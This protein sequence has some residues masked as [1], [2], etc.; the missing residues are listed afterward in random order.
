MIKELDYP[1]HAAGSLFGAFMLLC[2]AGASAFGAR[3]GTRVL[4]PVAVT[5]THRKHVEV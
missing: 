2:D 1:S 4:R 5:E 3:M